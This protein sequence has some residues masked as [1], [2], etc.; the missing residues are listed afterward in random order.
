MPNFDGNFGDW[1]MF[2]I[3]IEKMLLNKNNIDQMMKMTIIKKLL[4]NE[5]NDMWKNFIVKQY[6]LKKNWSELTKHYESPKR[7]NIFIKS[8]LIKM[9]TVQNKRDINGLKDILEKV[10]EFQSILNRL[11]AEYKAQSTILSQEIAI[12]FWPEEFEYLITRCTTLKK[13]VKRIELLYQDAF[14]LN[15]H[16][17]YQSKNRSDVTQKKNVRMVKCLFSFKE[18][19]VISVIETIIKQ[20]IVQETLN[21]M[22]REK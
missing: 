2:K 18:S 10:I 6:T 1:K 17:Q 14:L 7:I 16:V 20:L 15:V 3:V 21:I 4:T 5:P 22:K 11:G 19:L 8:I 12:K 13:M 9:K